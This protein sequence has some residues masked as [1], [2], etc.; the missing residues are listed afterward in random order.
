M[1]VDSRWF[2]RLFVRHSG[3]LVVAA[4]VV[5]LK[6]HLV[7]WLFGFDARL[8]AY[9]A[10]VVLPLGCRLVSLIVRLEF[11]LLGTYWVPFDDS[12]MSL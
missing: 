1:F 6:P 3:L 4:V 7:G 8:S 9:V 11:S 12:V 5:A 2:V 10:G